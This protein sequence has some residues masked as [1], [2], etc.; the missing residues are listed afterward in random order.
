MA[1]YKYLG[2]L[3]TEGKLLQ[4]DCALLLVANVWVCEWALQM[5][6]WRQNMTS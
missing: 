1:S 4:P 3:Q 2:C 5:T 6:S